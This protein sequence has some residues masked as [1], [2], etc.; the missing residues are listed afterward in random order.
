MNPKLK[1]ALIFVVIG[2]IVIAVYFVFIKKSPE[3]ANLA[4]EGGESSLPNVDSTSAGTT[5]STVDSQLSKDFLTVLLSIKNITLDDS[6]F[7]NVAFMNLKDSTILLLPDGSEGRPNPF[8]PIGSE[9]SIAQE[10]LSS[11]SPLVADDDSLLGDDT[12]TEITN[13][14]PAKTTPLTTKKPVTPKP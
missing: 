14:P 7:S 4:V 13:L 11:L 8:A 5:T 3:Q 9:S 2:I 1:N 6:I 10:S 12:S